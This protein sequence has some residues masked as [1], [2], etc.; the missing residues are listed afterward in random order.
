MTI[1]G[2]VI[3]ENKK[4]IFRKVYIKGMDVKYRIKCGWIKWKEMLGVICDKKILTRLKGI[5]HLQECSEINYIIWF[6]VLGCLQE[7]RTEYECCGNEM[8]MLR[9]MDRVTKDRIK[10][11]YVRGSIVI[12]SILEKIREN[13]LK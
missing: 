13:R 12:A 10:N 11:E 5:I 2:D 6:R 1:S 7:Y 9:W 4:Y 3:I 8:D